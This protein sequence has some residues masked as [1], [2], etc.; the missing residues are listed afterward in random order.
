M[1]VSEGTAAFL[2]ADWI[3]GFLRFGRPSGS[4]G[5]DGRPKLQSSQEEKR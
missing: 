5:P 1:L 4:E 3:C 2:R